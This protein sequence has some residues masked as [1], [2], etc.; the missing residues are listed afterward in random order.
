M[1]DYLFAHRK[2]VF[3][4]GDMAWYP[5][6]LR[7]GLRAFL[8]AT[9]RVMQYHKVWAE[10]LAD[11]L[12]TSGLR[13]VVVLGG[14]GGHLSV[15]I[16][17][18]LRETHGLDISFVVTDLNP[19]RDGPKALGDV[20]NFDYVAAPVNMTDVPGN[21]KGVR[22][23]FNAFHHLNPAQARATLAGA[24]EAKTPICVFEYTMNSW[25]GVLSSAA[26]PFFNMLIAPFVRP[27][28]WSHLLLTYAV[29]LY[30]LAI[31][32][33]G[34]MSNL[35]TYNRREFL[36]MTADLKNRYS[37]TVEYRSI[38]RHPTPLTCLVGMPA[39][40]AVAGPESERRGPDRRFR[41]HGEGEPVLIPAGPPPSTAGAAR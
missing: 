31:A 1:F 37:W 30:P 29:P 26:Y 16:Q 6:S 3:E 12:R 38:R 25:V 9:H 10:V 35:S 15:L 39:R 14:G 21:F 18:E 17:R 19:V 24:Y 2:T 33:D 5:K 23:V 27:F 4:L 28:K 41:T 8:N 32:F 7:D 36:E 11:V 20:R 40:R 13:Q 34:L 22:V